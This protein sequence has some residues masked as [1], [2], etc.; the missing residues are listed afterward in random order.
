MKFTVVGLVGGLIVIW[1]EL[2]LTCG[3]AVEVAWIVTKIPADV[4]GGAV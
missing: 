4:T 3:S 1:A 2:T